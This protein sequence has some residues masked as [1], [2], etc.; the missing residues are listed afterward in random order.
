MN[1]FTFT[2]LWNPHSELTSLKK[3]LSALQ[4]IDEKYL[5]NAAEIP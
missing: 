2:S 4:N 5:L 1:G 3:G